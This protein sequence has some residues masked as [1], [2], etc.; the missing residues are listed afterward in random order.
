MTFLSITAFVALFCGIEHG[1]FETVEYDFKAA[2]S[3]KQRMVVYLPPNYPQGGPY[4]V[5]YLLHGAGDD[6]TAW[7][8][9]GVGTLLDRLYAEKKIVAMIV[10]AHQL[11]GTWWRVRARSAGA[12]DPLRRV[13]LCDAR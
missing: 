10:V 1:K 13:A 3:G 8:Q 7:Q 11:A 9:Q 6:E 12:R 2:L 4:P 5:L